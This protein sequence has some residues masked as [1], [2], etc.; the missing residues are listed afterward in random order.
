[1]WWNGN[2]ISKLCKSTK[3][4]K[5]QSNSSS[6]AQLITLGIKRKSTETHKIKF[7]KLWFFLPHVIALS[8]GLEK[9]SRVVRPMYTSVKTAKLH[10]EVA[11]PA[12]G[13]DIFK[14]NFL[15]LNR[16]TYEVHSR[17]LETGLKQTI[18]AAYCNLLQVL[19]GCPFHALVR[20]NMKW[21]N[22]F[23][24]LCKISLGRCSR[25][26]QAAQTVCFNMM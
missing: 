23:Y 26:A 13:D 16:K 9:C 18:C 14:D 17:V 7:C 22:V 4:N 2:V 10:A 8:L 3:S 12:G 6:T 5:H 1:M 24:M 15:A 25:R 21:T 20:Q 11:L 19:H